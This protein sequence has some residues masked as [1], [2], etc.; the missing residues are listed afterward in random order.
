LDV[1]F[2]EHSNYLRYEVREGSANIKYSTVDNWDE[3]ISCVQLWI[4]YIQANADTT[5]SKKPDDDKLERQLKVMVAR[6]LTDVVFSTYRNMDWEVEKFRGGYLSIGDSNYANI[7][8]YIGMED[9]LINLQEGLPQNIKIQSYMF[10]R[11]S[12]YFVAGND[13]FGNLSCFRHCKEKCSS[14]KSKDDVI[15]LF[16]AEFSNSKMVEET[17]W[18]DEFEVIR[19]EDYVFKCVVKNDGN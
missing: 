10:C 9:L 7:N 12:H 19:K 15:D 14:V 2:I 11:Y 5:Y 4:D 6:Q 3:L 8:T 18:C 16:D 13:N 1:E 17:F